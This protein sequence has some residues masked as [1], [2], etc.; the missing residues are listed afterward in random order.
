MRIHRLALHIALLCSVTSSAGAA[1]IAGIKT[2]NIRDAKIDLMNNHDVRVAESNFILRDGFDINLFAHEPMIANPVHLTWDSAGR[3]YVACSWAYPQLKPGEVPDDKVIRLE[4][5]DGDGV[6]DRATVFADGLY[7]PT[8]IETANG[9]LYVA[10][11]PDIFFFKDTDGDGQADVREVVVTGFGIED[12]HHSI[13]AWRRGPGGW[14]YFQE[15]IFLNTQVETPYGM[16]R[17]YNGGVYQYNP[18]TQELR[19]FANV[20]V[21]NP[22]GHVFD[23]WG[24]SFLVDNPRVIYL[25]PGSGNGDRKIRLPNLMSSEKQCGGDVITGTHFPGEMRGQ[26]LTC[27]FKSRKIIPYEFTEAGSGFSATIHAPLVASSHPNFRPVDCKI[28]P[29]GALYVADWYNSI[30]NHAQH[31]FR[32]PRRD[33]EHGRIWR[34]TH[35][36]R[37]L[38]ERPKLA[39]AKV[40][41]LLN[42]LESPDTW[43]RHYARLELSGRD[44]NH[45][46]TAVRGWMKSRSDSHQ[47]LEGLWTLQNLECPDEA[48]LNLVLSTSDGRARAAA[49]RVLRYWYPYLS[50]PI[51]TL[52]RAANDVHPRVRLEAILAGGYMLDP[53]A[54][55]AVL[56][57]L[58]HPRDQSI[59]L[60]FP[61][62]IAALRPLWEPAFAAGDLVFA[63]PEHEAFLGAQA[64]TATE[65]LLKQVL[66]HGHASPAEIA[67]LDRQLRDKPVAKQ[68]NAVVG[69][70]VKRGELMQPALTGMLF[71]VVTD[72]GRNRPFGLGR[73]MDK[74][75]RHLESENPVMVE[76]SMELLGVWQRVSVAGEIKDVLQD[77]NRAWATRRTA[78]EALGRM[79][80][81]EWVAVLKSYAEPDQS[82]SH[83]YLAAFGLLRVDFQSAALIAADLFREQANDEEPVALVRAFVSVSGGSNALADALRDSTLH[84]SVGE[85]LAAYQ[86]LHGPFPGKLGRLLTPE[87]RGTL[88]EKLMAEPREKLVAAVDA[89]GDPVNGER[90][91]RRAEV[92][93]LSCHAINGAGPKLGP[94]LAAVGAAA[95]TE[96]I[97]ESILEPNKAIAEHYENQSVVTV[98]NTFHMG[99]V[100]FKSDAEIVLRDM[101]QGG[102][103]IR[104]PKDHVK[105]TNP[106]PS[107]MPGSLSNQLKNREEFLDLA[108][109]VSRLGRAGAYASSDAPVVRTWMRE[110]GTQVYSQ[111]NGLLPFADV[112]SHLS[113]QVDVQRAG[114][115]NFAV[116]DLSGL[117]LMVNDVPIRDLSGPVELPAG[118]VKL[119]FKLNLSER[120]QKGLRVELKALPKSAAR[121]RVVN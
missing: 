56:Q 47:L 81:P 110:N 45:T 6:A 42:A 28:G 35:K 104:I 34:V 3:L 102:K 73:S 108:H 41:Q 27:R 5:T 116:N 61:Q 101:T 51:A 98:D 10:Q 106:M 92:A 107:L 80:R 91:Y 30:I 96:Y 86:R 75:S 83:R 113:A 55:T 114:A 69:Q 63:K 65:A 16:V 95:T 11:S 52:A 7:I 118:R 117:A 85:Q 14:L 97:V 72:I 38:V 68:L 15:G 120:K 79:G 31:D 66:K 112:S 109:F 103:E 57:A 88:Q 78:A 17:N 2:A 19:I 84:V 67:R 71:D 23:R 9:G 26:M 99:V 70:L 105:R 94:D 33:N 93:C 119:T 32:D 44:A 39:G 21:G 43:T 12:S 46:A 87:N 111:V 8:G 59:D 121:F 76:K 50:D 29:D 49:V 77:P 20:G 100:I 64:G 22:W 115:V 58:D 13:S 60:A 53:H 48:S 89:M 36:E 54:L 40:A 18:R 1:D 90:V 25:T 82:L 4:D 62:T 74:L 24:Q 37:P